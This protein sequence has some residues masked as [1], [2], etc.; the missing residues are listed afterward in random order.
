MSSKLKLGESVCSYS[1]SRQKRKYG[2]GGTKDPEKNGIIQRQ[3]KDDHSGN[4]KRAEGGG[5]GYHVL[6][7]QEA[8]C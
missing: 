1:T 7:A 5:T 4:T 2:R 6:P 8:E 3:G